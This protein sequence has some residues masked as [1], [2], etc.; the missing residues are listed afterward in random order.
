MPKVKIKPLR[1]NAKSKAEL[2]HLVKSWEGIRERLLKYSKKQADKGE[3]WDA[4]H[5]Y[6]LSEGI[7]Y[8]ARDLR[9]I[10]PQ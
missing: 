9:K 4:A 5:N 1:L 10:M 3:Y 2:L 6:L 7:D 8:C